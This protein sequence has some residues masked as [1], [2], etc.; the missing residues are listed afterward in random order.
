MGTMIEFLTEDFE[1]LNIYLKQKAPSLLLIIVDE[2]THEHCLPRFLPNLETEIPFQIIELEA[3]EEQKTLETVCNL[4]PVFAE[5]TADRNALVINLGGG[6][7]T[8][9]GGFSASIYKRGIDFINIPTSLLGMCDASLGGKTGVDLE[10]LKNLVGTFALPD[11]VFVDVNFLKTLPKEELISGFAEMLKHGLIADQLHWKNLIELKEITPENIAPY[12]KDSM[13]IKQNIVEQDFYEKNSRKILNF[14]HTIG[15]AVESLYLKAGNPISHGEAVAI[16]MIC[17]ARLSFVENII[18]EE[19]SNAI[20][21]NIKRYFQHRAVIFNNNEI[22]ALMIND[23]KNKN[24]KI[25]FSLVDKIGSC[26]Y[27]REC[28]KENILD[29]IDYYKNSF[30]N[31]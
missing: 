28:S 30:R 10:N 3:G 12:I 1:E 31:N 29:A 24:S 23:K 22:F 21:S 26:L 16:G 15:H 14:G 18:S 19:V 27:N 7:V 9:L 5:F 17:E 2:N 4:L 25:Q 11:K 8:D 20:I 6:V 13:L